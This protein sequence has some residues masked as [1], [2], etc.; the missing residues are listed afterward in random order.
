MLQNTQGQELVWWW[1]SNIFLKVSVQLILEWDYF[2]FLIR[3]VHTHWNQKCQI[4]SRNSFKI[5]SC[6]IH[7]LPLIEQLIKNHQNGNSVYFMMLYCWTLMTYFMI[8]IAWDISWWRPPRSPPAPSGRPW[9]RRTCYESPGPR[10]S[11]R[12][13]SWPTFIMIRKNFNKK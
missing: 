5:T 6:I 13:R 4:R 2:I 10:R 9:R 1:I 8:F 12:S 11:S 3:S 7:Y